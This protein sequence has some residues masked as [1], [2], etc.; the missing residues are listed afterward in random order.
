[1]LSSEE[2]VPVGLKDRLMMMTAAAML[3]ATGVVSARAQSESFDL[4]G[5]NGR[6]VSTGGAATSDKTA[7]DITTSDKPISDPAAAEP[8]VTA[9]DYSSAGTAAFDHPPSPD[10]PLAPTR[11]YGRPKPK[12]PKIYIL[13]KLKKYGFPV[14]PPLISYKAA[15]TTP[16]YGT[17]P[18]ADPSDAN[19]PPTVAAIPTLPVRPKPKREDNPYAPTG[20]D[21]GSLRLY[22]YVEADTG[23]DTNPNYQAI[24]VKGSSFLHGETGLKLESLWSQNSLTADMHAGYWDY[25]QVSTANRPDVAGTVTGRIDVAKDTQIN[26]ESRLGISTQL[27]GLAQLTVPGSVFITNRPIVAGIGQTTGA[28]QE[29][30]RLKLDLRGS[31]DRFMFGNAAQSDGTE[32]LLSLDNY[33]DY[34]LTGR[35]SY[36]L[37]PG[38]IPFVE[39]RGDQRV[40]DNTYDIDGFQ[41]NSSGVAAKAGAKVDM[42]GWLTGEVSAGYADRDYVDPRLPP[43]A[44]P[45][46]DASLIYTA[47]PLTKLTL[48]A[49]TDLSETTLAYASGAVTRRVAGKIEHALLRNLLLTGQASYQINQYQGSPLVEQLYSTTLGAEYSLT[50]SIVIRGSFSRQWLTSN[51]AGDDYTANVFLVGLKLQE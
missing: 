21:V 40:Y 7:G 39:M 48:T 49:A 18:P 4:R 32:L 35:A 47:T 24:D 50:R 2:R 41:R 31:I 28:S 51:Q 25:F 13:R 29:F 12:K 42:T 22:P 15:K 43:I 14:L 44:A 19:P 17:T 3:L 30:N 34:G 9:G 8:A 11:N 10:Q 27:P 1:M 5:D 45:T 23:Y 38:L 46:A 6:P 33:N 16:K 20:V 36:E 26:L 37:S